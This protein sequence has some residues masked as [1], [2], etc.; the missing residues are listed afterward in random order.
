[1]ARERAGL[2][3]GSRKEGSAQRVLVTDK[4]RSTRP[5][6]PR[7]ASTFRNIGLRSAST[8]SADEAGR[9]LRRSPQRRA[10]NQDRSC[11]PSADR[12]SFTKPQ[13]FAR[14]LGADALRRR[15]HGVEVRPARFHG[16]PVPGAR[17][18]SRNPCLRR[19]PGLAHGANLSGRRIDPG[20]LL[21]AP[22]DVAETFVALVRRPCDEVAVGWPARAAQIAY[23]L[24]SARPST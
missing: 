11:E 3:W 17:G 20:P 1:M 8:G 14:R 6:S 24:A 15:L 22:E 9:G 12:D 23:A 16:E 2:P 10:T 18:L 7:P 5:A 13:H 4:L 21:Y 19:L